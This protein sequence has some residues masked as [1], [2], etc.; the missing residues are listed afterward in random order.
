MKKSDIVFI[1]FISF[2]I[3][4][5]VAAHV[6]R[7]G[8]IDAQSQTMIELEQQNQKQVQEILESMKSIQNTINEMGKN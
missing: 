3:G 1:W 2:I 6:R 5:S 8:Q 7:L 4:I